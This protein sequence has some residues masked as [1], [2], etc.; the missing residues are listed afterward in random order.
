MKV[1]KV[2]AFAVRIDHHYKVGGRAQRP[3]ALPGTPYYF[4]PAWAQVY[5]TKLMT[6][7]LKVTSDTGLVGWGEAQAPIA[8]EVV[9]TVVKELVG[10]ALLGRDPLAHEEAY[11][12]LM[13]MMDVR[14]H[15]SGFMVDAIAGVDIALWDL[16]GRDC[17]VSLASLLGG[18]VTEPIPLYISGLRKPTLEG[19]AEIARRYVEQGFGGIKLFLGARP[20]EAAK[21]IHHIR[22]AAGEGVRLM[23]D[24]LWGYD[25]SEALAL[26]PALEEEDVAFLECPIGVEQLEDHARLAR[27]TRVP[28]AFGENLRTARSFLP[29]I[30]TGGIQILQPDVGRVGITECLRIAHVAQAFGRQ[31]AWHVGTCSPL[32]M[33]AS[34][35]LAAALPSR[36]QHEHQAELLPAVAPLLREPLVVESG[37]GRLPP[38]PGLGVEVDE[39]AVRERSSVVCSVGG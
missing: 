6:C 22:R 4:E 8:P 10:P 38:G 3:G 19:Q 13:G 9:V 26:V 25:L 35:H 27:A 7:L 18:R 12:R 1:R 24:L 29:W 30:Q 20:D 34:W 32:A 2:E 14:G 11:R 33:V 23:V 31:V 17:G 21:T 16:K 5:S 15:A 39:A 28:I 36:L 37:E